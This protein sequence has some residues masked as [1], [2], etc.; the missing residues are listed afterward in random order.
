MRTDSEDSI[1]MD[2]EREGSQD[3]FF[4]VQDL[5]L[6]EF[7]MSDFFNEVVHR[8]SLNIF[9]LRGYKNA[10]DSNEMEIWIGQDNTFLLFSMKVPVH[11]GDS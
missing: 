11:E 5:S 6:W 1:R 2:S 4:F 3:F 8:D 9:V 10:D 7:I